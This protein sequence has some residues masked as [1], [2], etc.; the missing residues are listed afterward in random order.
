MET[1]KELFSGR[2]I[3]R[4]EAIKWPPRSPHLTPTGVFFGS[5]LNILCIKHN[6]M[7]LMNLKEELQQH[8]D[9]LLFRA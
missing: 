1:Q 2:R 6:L 8:A 4:G 7:T 9:Q 3:G 5:I